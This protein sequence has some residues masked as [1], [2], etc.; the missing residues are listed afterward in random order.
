MATVEF[1]SSDQAIRRRGRA[2]TT[3]RSRSPTASSWSLVGPSGCGKTTALR[4]VAGLEKPTA[5][6]IVIGDRVVND[7]Q[8]GRRDIAMVFQNYALYPHMTVERNIG[9]RPAPAA[10]AAGPDRRAG[11]RGERAAR[12]RRPAQA[13]AGAALGRAAPARGD[14]PGARAPAA[15]VPARRAALQPR[16]QAADAAARRAQA[17][18][19]ARADDVDLRHPRPGRGDDARRPHRRDGRRPHPAARRAR[20]SVRPPRRTSSWPGSSAARR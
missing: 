13:P 3:C 20:G 9:V 6:E 15:G 12:A 4:M 1:R 18:P 10:D 11:A 19:P 2:W 7:E 5:G 17:H 8:P 16:R 14:G